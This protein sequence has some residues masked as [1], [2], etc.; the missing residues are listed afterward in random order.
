MGDQ[1]DDKNLFRSLFGDIER[2]SDDR[3]PEWRE[4]P[5]RKAA[6]QPVDQQYNDAGISPWPEL[7]AEA[8][9]DIDND[10]YRGNGIQ[11]KRL[12]KLRQGKLQP[13]ASIDL[14]GMTRVVALQELQEFIGECHSRGITCIHIVH[15]K[16][17]Q[18]EGGNAVL[19]P[20]VAVWLK[21]MPTVL[22]YCPAQAGDG[23]EGALYVLLKNI[24]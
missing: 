14:H 11:D 5:R 10:T 24:A 12:K 16:G 3:T 22:A 1:S 20:S 18:S 21:Q 8:H 4:K 13:Q 7:D 19:K 15:G 23:G 6:R 2:I 9:P 17:H